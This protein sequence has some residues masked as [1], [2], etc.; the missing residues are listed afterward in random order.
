MS[1]LDEIVDVF[2][3]GP[4]SWAERLQ[5]EILLISPE[6]NEFTAKWSGSSRSMEKKLGI[7]IFPKVKGNVVQDLDVNSTSWTIPISFDGKDCDLN[8]TAFFRAAK[9]RGVWSI[10][11]PVHGFLG[12]QLVRITQND[13]PVTSGGIIEVDTEWIEP[14]DETTLLT[15]AEAS[16]AVQDKIDGLA[17]SAFDQFAEGLD[18]STEALENGIS[19]TVQGIANVTDFVLS[20]LTSSVDALSTA[21]NLIQNGIN[22]TL[23]ATVLDVE[24]LAGQ[25]QEL[26]TTPS[27]ATTSI[28]QSQDLYSELASEF[29]ALLPDTDATTRLTA[30]EANQAIVVELA[31][32][33][34]LQAYGTIA[35]NGIKAAQAAGATIPAT[36]IVLTGEPVATRAQAV[37]AAANTATVFDD[38]TNNLEG[39]Q[40]AFENEDI[41]QQYFAQPL[42]FSPA[43]QLVGQ[44]IQFLL[45]A[46][47]DLKVERRFVLDRPRSPVEIA[48]TEYGGPGNN[49]ANIDL[50]IRS[51]NLKDNEI[52]LLPAGR[53]VLIYA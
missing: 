22:D 50:F 27:L 2:L 24:A 52:Y 31:L 53:E 21:M 37:E 34:A 18:A 33:S 35:V 39:I 48:M 14:I 41:D 16:A 49:D 30:A 17:T 42:S 10:T 19:T 44:T 15:A 3:G 13:E 47:F 8:A 26:I 25:I 38:L 46:A 40:K 29:S 1:V 12:L 7:F 28:E 6:G 5:S 20:P 32:S 51:N 4:D 36:T 45:L 9:E 23:A 11:H 43:A